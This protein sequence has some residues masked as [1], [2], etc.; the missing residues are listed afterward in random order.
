MRWL[1]SEHLDQV[2][3]QVG[4][5]L[6]EKDLYIMLVQGPRYNFKSGGAHCE[7]TLQILSESAQGGTMGWKFFWILTALD[8]QCTIIF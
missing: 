5:T 7:P 8:W 3:F 1:Y 2:N 4:T 6:E